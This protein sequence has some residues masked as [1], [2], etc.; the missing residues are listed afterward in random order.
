[1]VVAGLLTKVKSAKLLSTGQTVNFTQDAMRV[2]F[3]GLSEKPP[4]DPITT[5]SIECEGEPRQD[6]IFVRRENKRELA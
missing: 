3:T 5:I 6:N 1:M 4:D 2:R